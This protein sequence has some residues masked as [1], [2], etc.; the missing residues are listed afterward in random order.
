MQETV[1]DL[2]LRMERSTNNGGIKKSLSDIMLTRPKEMEW[3]LEIT[4]MKE[5]I[6]SHRMRAL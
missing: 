5:M 3:L 4:C 1:C 6:V 2:I